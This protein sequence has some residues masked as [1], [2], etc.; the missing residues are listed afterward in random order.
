MM[1]EIKLSEVCTAVG[2]VAYFHYGCALRCVATG[3][4]RD[5]D[6]VSIFLATQRAAVQ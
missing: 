3:E 1:T 2:C 5:A 4:S 6:G